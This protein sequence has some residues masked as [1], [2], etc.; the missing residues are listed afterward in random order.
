MKTEHKK[1][2]ILALE[3]IIQCI[4]LLLT[5]FAFLYAV[6]SKKA[7]QYVHI[8]H[9]GII[10]CAAIIFLIISFLQMQQNWQ[11]IFQSPYDKKTENNGCDNHQH[12][13]FHV[14]KKCDDNNSHKCSCHL[15]HLHKAKFLFYL[16][17]FILPF[18]LLV[19]VPYK[20]LSVDSLAFG[21]TGL[22]IQQH[23][24][25]LPPQPAKPRLLE[26]QNGFVIMDDDSFGRWL[27][28][29]YLNLDSWIGKKIKIDGAVWKNTE[30]LTENEFAL[31]RMMMVCCAADM[32][33]VGL[34]ASWQNANTLAGD[35]WVRLIGTISK[36][37]Y[38]GNFEP[39]ILVEEVQKI[40]R[41]QLEYVYPF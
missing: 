38:E 32:Q 31:G 5:G 33:P 2:D 24:S 26:L 7:L 36:T 19:F 17:I 34:V 20:P 18:L 1:I 23:K 12:S 15:E 22:S 25:Q 37:E 4:I 9:I 10:V 8:R 16:I 6:I 27:P 29:L 28:E 35:E 13:H 11:K 39:L 21:N 41:P 14:N 30:F 40:Q 3:K